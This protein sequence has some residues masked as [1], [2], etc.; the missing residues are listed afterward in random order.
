MT[1]CEQRI[2]LFVFLLKSTQQSPIQISI[3]TWTCYMNLVFS[4]YFAQSRITVFVKPQSNMYFLRDVSH[5]HFSF[6]PNSSCQYAFPALFT[7]KCVFFGIFDLYVLLWRV[8][9]LQCPF[10][11][12]RYILQVGGSVV[13]YAVYH[14]CSKVLV[15]N[16]SPTVQFFVNGMD[17]MYL[18]TVWGN[19]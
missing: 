2:Y 7:F 3:T 5:S 19:S 11:E 13:R 1:K 10:Q 14:H 9:E 6:R 17:F 18:W 12:F 16:T 4:P 8:I 15:I